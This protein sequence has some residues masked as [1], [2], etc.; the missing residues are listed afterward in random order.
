MGGLDENKR[1]NHFGKISESNFRVRKNL[2]EFKAFGVNKVSN[3]V[4]K[5]CAHS[6]VKPLKSIFEN[7]LNTGEVP[8]EWGEANVTP[9]FKKGSKL[10]PA[11]YRPGS[12]TCDLLETLDI[13]TDTMNKR[14]CVDLVLLDFA[15]AFDKVSRAKLIKKLESRHR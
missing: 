14:Y 10:I 12:L 6:F 7:S 3:A 2:N 1:R 9:I 5:N 13:I 15:K 8:K 4:L 11:N